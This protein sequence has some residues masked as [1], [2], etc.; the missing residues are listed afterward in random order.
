VRWLLKPPL[1]DVTWPPHDGLP[2]AF[3]GVALDYWRNISYTYAR[4]VALTMLGLIMGL[5]FYNVS[6][7]MPVFRFPVVLSVAILNLAVTAALC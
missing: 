3:A 6:K 1:I 2:L 5:V 4:L 7:R